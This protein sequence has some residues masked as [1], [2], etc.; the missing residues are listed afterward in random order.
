M[1]KRKTSKS[2]FQGIEKK[3]SV[4]IMIIVALC[5]ITLGVV[6]GILSYRSSVSAIEK[7]IDQTAVVAS[8]MVSASLD[9]YVAVAYETGSI[10][11]LADPDR[12]IADKKE[13][14]E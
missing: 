10:A 11:R 9:G 4:T 3:I 1:R 5:N 8:N 14:I 12:S 6:T 7:T 13:I 2:E